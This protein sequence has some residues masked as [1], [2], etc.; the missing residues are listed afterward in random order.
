MNGPTGWSS[1]VFQAKAWGLRAARAVRNFREGIPLHPKTRFAATTIAAEIRSPL[2]TH[3]AD[4]EQAYQLGKIQNLRAAARRLNGLR[5]DGVFSFW[6]HVGRPSRRSGFVE[7]RMLRQGCFMPSVGGGLCQLSN[8]LY[9]AAVAAGCQIVERHA[10]SRVVPGSAAANG[11]DA[12]VAWNYVDLRFRPPS[13]MQLEVRLTSSELIVRLRGTTA[14][15][16]QVLPLLDSPTASREA[17]SCFTC[18]EESCLHHGRAAALRIAYTRTAFLVD[19]NWPEF[20]QYVQKHGTAADALFVPVNG[21]RFGLA[22]YRWPV[23]CDI[24]EARWATAKRSLRA[25]RLSGQ[26]AARQTALL[27]GAEELADAY[28]ASLKPE[29]TNLVVAQSLLPFLWRKGHLGGRTFSVLMTRPPMIEIERALDAALQHHPE[30]VT[31]GDFRAPRST[32]ENEAE[33]LEAAQEIITPHA[34][35]A[36][37]FCHKTTRLNW[38]LPA[39]FDRNPQPAVIG[40][41]GPLVA[42]RGAYEVR[43]AARATGAPV[44]WSGANFEAADFWK[45][46]DATHVETPGLAW[47][48]RVSVLL[49]PSIVESRPRAALAAIAAG[50]PVI[51]TSAVGLEAGRELTIMDNAEDLIEALRATQ[52]Y[53]PR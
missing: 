38:T 27:T 13:A 12:T 4:K 45:G 6:R 15:G 18:G 7:G 10:H 8:A 42:R 50:V 53:A 52:P 33:A 48:G 34:K 28:A 5:V 51:A 16:K 44:L 46:I 22:R 35:V 25:R 37:M 1:L 9:Q 30:R 11:E 26:G 29:M 3:E 23:F 17:N 43:D 47:L 49:A 14:A 21:E 2:W 40:F 32:I 19:E 39:A 41:A 24:H 36:A 31:L 20:R